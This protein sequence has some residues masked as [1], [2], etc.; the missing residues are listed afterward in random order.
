MKCGTV[1]NAAHADCSWSLRNWSDVISFR[2]LIFSILL[3]Y[4]DWF[5]IILSRL[6]KISSFTWLNHKLNHN[7]AS[8]FPIFPLLGNSFNA[9]SSLEA[10]FFWYA[11][12]LSSICSPRID[13]IPSFP[14]WYVRRVH[15]RWRHGKYLSVV[16]HV[17]FKLLHGR[18]KQTIYR[19]YHDDNFPF[20]WS[21]LFQCEHMN[22]SGEKY[23]INYE[24]FFIILDAQLQP[25]GYV[26]CK[27]QT[28]EVAFHCW[29]GSEQPLFSTC[30]P[31]YRVSIFGSHLVSHGLQIAIDIGDVQL[32]LLRLQ[33]WSIQAGS[34]LLSFLLWVGC[35]SLY[36]FHYLLNEFLHQYFLFSFATV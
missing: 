26:I 19:T 11:Y 21:H 24:R 4:S 23:F 36:P 6:S 35:K 15:R 7:G 3:K 1:E 14:W 9:T 30:R 28:N 25:S 18:L 33:S 10:N 22:R 17:C 27:Q 29:S 32:L 34:S 31:H 12:L 5:I 13:L 20:S 2:H 16:L 8:S